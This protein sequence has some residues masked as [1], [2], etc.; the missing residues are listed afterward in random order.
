MK[1][2]TLI[3]ALALACAPM[4]STTPAEPAPSADKVLFSVEQVSPGVYRLMLDNGASHQIGYNLC[5]SVLE[6]RNGTSWTRAHTDICTA[7]I[8]RLNP[9][10]D[11]TFEKRP[12]PLPAG[13]YRWV[14]RIESPLDAPPAT[15]ATG[16]FRVG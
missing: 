11:A 13:E 6:R 8:R 16:V 10:A 2:A 7:D 15:L 14:T 1:I 9:G 12:G 5:S 3:C 4:S